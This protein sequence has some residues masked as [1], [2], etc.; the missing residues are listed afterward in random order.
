ME[1]WFGAYESRL[2]SDLLELSDDVKK[3]KRNLAMREKR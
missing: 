1:I 3:T 2:F